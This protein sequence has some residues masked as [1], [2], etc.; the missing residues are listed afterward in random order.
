[1]NHER[2][3]SRSDSNGLDSAA[4]ACASVRTGLLVL[5]LDEYSQP[6]RFQ[7]WQ[8]G[9]HPTFV[10]TAATLCDEEVYLC[11]RVRAT[12]GQHM[13]I[14]KYNREIP[15]TLLQQGPACQYKEV[16]RCPNLHALCR[17]TSV[18]R[19][20]SNTSRT[21]SACPLRVASC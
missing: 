15:R 21:R 18:P 7:S 3:E 1:M 16:F 11:L 10:Q 20:P 13:S 12:A 2:H 19:S 9:I 6:R 4:F 14:A 8:S 17:S 5:C